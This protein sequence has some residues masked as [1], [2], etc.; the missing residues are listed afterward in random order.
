MECTELWL[1]MD[2]E[3]TQNLWDM[4]KE[5][6]GKGEIIVGVCYLIRKSK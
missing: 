2:E 6:R 5:K 4:F 1:G 3:Q